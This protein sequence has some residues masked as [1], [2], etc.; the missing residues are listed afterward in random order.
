MIQPLAEI[1]IDAEIA[2]LPKADLHVHAEAAPRLARVI[3]LLEE[4]EL[5]AF[6]RNA[7]RASFTTTERRSALH[8]QLAVRQN[9]DN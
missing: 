5:L 3:D 9:A 7:I 8:S 6:T 4:A 2:A 1:P